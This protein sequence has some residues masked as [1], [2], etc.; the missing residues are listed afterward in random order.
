[1]YTSPTLLVIGTDCTSSCKSKVPYAHEGH[2]KNRHIVAV[3]KVVFSSSL[4]NSPD[5][6]SGSQKLVTLH[7][8]IPPVV[9]PPLSHSSH[10][11]PSIISFLP[12]LPLHYLIPPV[13]TPS[14]SHSSHCYPSIISF[15][16]LLPLHYLIPPSFLYNIYLSVIWIFFLWSRRVILW[17]IRNWLSPSDIVSNKELTLTEWYCE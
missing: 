16:P 13:V 5:F 14:L 11:Y 4:P 2:S 17:V 8:L 6:S 9:T 10:C 15:L 3:T 1:M 12:L 7:Y